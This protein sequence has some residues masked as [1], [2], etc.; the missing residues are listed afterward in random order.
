MEEDSTT[1]QYSK[2]AFSDKISIA[3]SSD[4]NRPTKKKYDDP[5]RTKG[6]SKDLRVAFSETGQNDNDDEKKSKKDDL[7]ELKEELK[8]MGFEDTQIRSVLKFTHNKEEAINLILSGDFFE[9]NEEEK[10]QQVAIYSKMVIAVRTDLKMGTGKIAAQV[11]HGVLGAYKSALAKD[12]LSVSVWEECGEPKIVVKVDGE[13]D[14]RNILM[15]CKDKDIPC[16][17]ITD[18]GRT[19]IDP[20]TVTVCS[21]GPAPDKVIDEIT[22][23]FKLL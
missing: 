5:L 4:N 23:K 2:K 10:I 21:V 20:G 19:Q 16:C 6:S 12:P 7:T 22:G 9:N 17:L 8:E 15:S 1:N 3:K 18:A 14:L 13:L 11:G